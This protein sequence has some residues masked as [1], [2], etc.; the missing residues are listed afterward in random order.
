MKLNE[1]FIGKMF[2]HPQLKKVRIISTVDG[3]RV[4]VNAQV[5]DRGKGWSKNKQR[6]IGHKNRI[7]W[8]RGENREYGSEHQ[9][10][11]N[12]LNPKLNQ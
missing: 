11:V 3:T 7:G 12:E 10:N 5:I 9:V 1:Q 4:M 2:A 6:Y 8:M